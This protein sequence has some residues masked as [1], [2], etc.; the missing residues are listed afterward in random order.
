[1]K[2]STKEEGLEEMLNMITITLIFTINYSNMHT[3]F[4]I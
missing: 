3:F 2:I 4:V 1:M